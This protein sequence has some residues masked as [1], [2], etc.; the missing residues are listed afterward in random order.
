MNPK[1]IY[2]IL[3]AIFALTILGGP[4][5]AQEEPAEL[6]IFYSPT[7]YECSKVK[8]EVIP[9]IEKEFAAKISIKYKDISDIENYK[10]LL[11]LRLKF[12]PEMNIEVPVI[13]MKGKFLTGKDDIKN[14]LKDFIANALNASGKEE[15]LPGIDLVQVFKRFK[16]AGVMAAGLEDGINPCAFTVIV[17]FISY[18]SLQG[19]LKKT[20]LIVGLSFIGTIF[21]TYFLIGLGIFNFLYSLRNFW[22]ITKALNISV[23]LLSVFLGI[24]AV[25]DFIKF[26]STQDTEGQLLQLPKPVKNRIHAVIGSHYRR[27]VKPGAESPGQDVFRL[28]TS[29]VIT[30]FLV[31]LLEAVCTAQLYVPTITVILKTTPLKLQAFGYLAVYNLMFIVPLLIIFLFALLGVTS[32]QFAAFL[33]KHLALIK[34]LMA[35]LFFALGIFLIWRA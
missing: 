24:L 17:F 35:S 34:I 18:L 9:G 1:K 29:A 22:I 12:S 15:V 2:S 26:R 21:A 11:S 16:L 19:Y 25:Y 27:Q 28:I 8:N 4:T 20:L 10:Y 32:G 13:F 14:D 31:T 33:K 30:G 7:C 5:L 3:A 23:G 6:L